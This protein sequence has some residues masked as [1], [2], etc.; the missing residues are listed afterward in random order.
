MAKITLKEKEDVVIEVGI[1]LLNKYGFTWA[2]ELSREA[3][4]SWKL[5]NKVLK[6]LRKWADLRT[7]RVGQTRLFIDE[8]HFALKAIKKVI[9]K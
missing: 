3:R 4:C 5:A 2:A 7:Y 6:R 8:D 1:K 9:K